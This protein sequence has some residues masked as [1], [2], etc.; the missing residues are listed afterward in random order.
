MKGVSFFLK[1]VAKELN[2]QALKE[3]GQIFF[4]NETFVIYIDFHCTLSHISEN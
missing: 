3:F 1:G 2:I 4:Y